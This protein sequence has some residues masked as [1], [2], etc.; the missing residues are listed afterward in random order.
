M[1]LVCGN[2]DIYGVKR[3]AFNSEL[4]LTYFAQCR[5]QRT[6]SEWFNFKMGDIRVK[7]L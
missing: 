4:Y 2:Y 7:F 3:C 5:A 6:P 1:R